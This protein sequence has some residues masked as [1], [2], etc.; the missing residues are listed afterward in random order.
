MNWL[1]YKTY[2]AANIAVFLKDFTWEENERIA[3]KM[4][5]HEWKFP[6]GDKKWKNP[7]KDV[8]YNFAP[9]LDSDVRSTIKH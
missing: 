1:N 5:G 3:S 8:D 4:I 9:E 6:T 7:A 2:K